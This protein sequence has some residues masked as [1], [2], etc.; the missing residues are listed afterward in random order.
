ML[1]SIAAL[2]LL[3]DAPAAPVP[4]QPVI[5]A[6]RPAELANQRYLPANTEVLLRMNGDVS[7]KR[8][9]EGDTFSLSV[10]HNVMLDGYVV[11]PAGTRA[12][13]EVTW[14]TGKG[15]FG[16]SGKIN[17]ELRYIELNGTSIP[18]EGKYRQEGDGNTVAT[19]G[20]V[21]VAGPFAALITGKTGVIPRGRELTAVTRDALPVVLPGPPIV[22]AVTA[23][24]P[25]PVGATAP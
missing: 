18:I 4:V 14:R 21:V 1:Y 20:T 3:A 24:A 19:V 10:V 11:I 17:I 9:R 8:A 23:S 7:T 5:T 13:G 22:P 6:Q 25:T 12:V 2:M 15:M 16:K